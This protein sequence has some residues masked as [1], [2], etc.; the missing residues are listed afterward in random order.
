M[1]LWGIACVCCGL[2]HNF[3]GLATARWFLGLF[4]AGL[5]PGMTFQINRPTRPLTQ[6]NPLSGCNFYLSCWYKRSEF[7]VRSAIFFSAAAIAGSFGGLLAA[8]ISQMDGV[9]GKAGWA[10]IFILEG[11]IT[12]IIGVVSVWMVHD[13][14]D[15]ATFL[16]PEDRLRVYH[17]LKADQQASAE[18]ESFSWKYVV[19]S[20]KDWKTYTGCL[21]YMGAGGGL[22]GFSIFLPTSMQL[23]IPREIPA[24]TSYS[25]RRTRLQS[26]NRPA[27]VGTTVHR[28]RDADRRHR[29]HRGQNTPARPMRHGRLVSRRDRLRD[30]AQRPPA[31]RQIRRHLPGR[32]GHLSLHTEHGDLAGEQH[33]GS[34]QARRVAGRGDGLGEPSG[35][36]HQ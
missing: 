30:P 22:Y 3:A 28:C 27:D 31:R 21:I 26:N 33:R 35:R 32:H 7:G 13:F 16:S 36:G 23:H 11:L 10:W 14:P 5:F 29:L 6:S 24:D 18:H 34:V 2:V 12:V 15:E 1:V 9:G 20:L 19:A 25:P 8:A 17:R 4:E